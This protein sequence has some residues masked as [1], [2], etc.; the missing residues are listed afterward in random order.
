MKRSGPFTEVKRLAQMLVRQGVLLTLYAGADKLHRWVR[1]HPIPRYSRLSDD[2]WIGGQ[3]SAKGLRYLA[4]QGVTGIVNLRGEHDY[5]HRVDAGR[6][7]YLHLPTNDNEAPAL[8]LL[9]AGVDFIRAEVDRGGRVYIHCWEGL[10]RGPTMAAAYFISRGETL[11]DAWACIRRVRPFVRPTEGQMQRLAL[12][13]RVYTPDAV[14][15]TVPGTHA[16]GAPLVV[17]RPG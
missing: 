4:A 2:V 16:E 15:P 14:L 3:P 12:F 8:D 11:P 6:M 10:G 13:A 7:R 1:G 9:A 17:G 5:A